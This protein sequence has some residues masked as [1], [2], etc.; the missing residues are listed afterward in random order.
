MP[1]ADWCPLD[2]YANPLLVTGAYLDAAARHG[3]AVH[4]F[5]PVTS[6]DPAP[7]GG[8]L[9]TAGGSGGPRRR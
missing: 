8:Y 1:L 9:V 3:A 2:G 4:A 5:T 7:G 6:I